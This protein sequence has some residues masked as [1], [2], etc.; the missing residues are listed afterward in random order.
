MGIKELATEIALWEQSGIGS[1]LAMKSDIVSEMMRILYHGS[2]YDREDTNLEDTPLDERAREL[3]TEI[4][5]KY[6]EE[7]DV[8]GSAIYHRIDEATEELFN[9]YNNQGAVLHE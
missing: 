3:A 4:T 2:G 1:C 5:D 8:D 6:F 9:N 7:A